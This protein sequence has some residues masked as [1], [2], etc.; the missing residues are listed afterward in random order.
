LEPNWQQ[1]LSDFDYK[2][3]S[4]FGYGFDKQCQQIAETEQSLL[5]I[6]HQVI[7]DCSVSA[8]NLLA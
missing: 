1:T 6:C 8:I 5:S 2:S 7:Q 4:A 3:V